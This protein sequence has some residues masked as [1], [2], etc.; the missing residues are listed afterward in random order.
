MTG[1]QIQVRPA[2]VVATRQRPAERDGD[3][4]EAWVEMA[5][6]GSAGTVLVVTARPLASDWRGAS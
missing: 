5:P 2:T 1:R 4:P 3:L 6:P